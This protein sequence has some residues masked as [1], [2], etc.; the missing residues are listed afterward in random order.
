[1]PF[2]HIK[3]L[4]P[5]DDPDISEVLKQLSQRF[6][7]ANGIDE[8]HVTVTWEYF[9]PQHY[10]FG[11][12][13]GDAL[14]PQRHQVLVDLLVPDFNDAPTI[15]AMMQSIATTLEE[16]LSIPGKAIFIHTRFA[17]SGMVLDAGEIVRW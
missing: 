11:G 4:P 7:E 8:R 16:I 3:S 13:S 2:I 14:D 12:V 5:V 15:A 1:M 9:Q 6:A 10:R 17:A